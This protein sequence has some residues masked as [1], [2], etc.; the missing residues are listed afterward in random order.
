M[1][2]AEIRCDQA[3]DRHVASLT[4][5]CRN[6]LSTEL[7]FPKSSAPGIEFA[8]FGVSARGC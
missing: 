7:I 4:F 8:C 5:T 1:G 6:S 3:W 2:T